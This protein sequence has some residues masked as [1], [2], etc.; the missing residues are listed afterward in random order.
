MYLYI[1]RY[2]FRFGSTYRHVYIYIHT[3]IY[4]YIDIDIDIDIDMC[5]YTPKYDWFLDQNHLPKRRPSCAI[6]LPSNPCFASSTFPNSNPCR[7]HC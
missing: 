3:H 6:F 5:L 2:G 4:I 7:V 1:Y